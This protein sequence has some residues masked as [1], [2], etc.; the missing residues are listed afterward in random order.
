MPGAPGTPAVAEKKSSTVLTNQSIIEMV[1]A[2]VPEA[3]IIG[4]IR[5]SKT[6]FD[7]STQAIIA[8]SKSDVPPAVIE[9]MRNPSGPGKPAASAIPPPVPAA[10]TRRC[11]CWAACRS[12]SR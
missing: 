1:G 5:A 12:R 3:V 2:E 11:R 7:L 6:K 8:L 4:H 10:D 9:A